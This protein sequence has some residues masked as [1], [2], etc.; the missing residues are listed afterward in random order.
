MNTPFTAGRMLGLLLLT[1]SFFAC[2][3]DDE[4]LTIDYREVFEN[5]AEIVHASYEDSYRTVADLKTA[6]DD[7]VANPTAEGLESAKNLWLV[8]RIP[9]GQ[10]E[11]YRFY[12]GPID[13]ENGPEGLINA[14]PIDENFID[15]VDGNATAGLINDPV[16]YPTID[17][18]TLADLNESISETSIYT[19]YHA[20]EFL[21]WG[22]DLSADGPGERPYTDYV[23]DGTGTADHQARR[24]EYLQVV[25]DLLLDHLAE[26]RDEWA[27]R[28]EY[29]TAFLATD[30]AVALGRIFTSLGELSKGELAG[31]RM[32][33]AVDSKD[34][35]NEHSCFSDNTDTDIRM[36]LEGI[37]NVYYG[38]YTRTGPAADVIQGESL[39]QKAA[40]VDA[41][42]ADAVDAAFQAAETAVE[43]IPRPFDQA[44]LNNETLILNAVEALRELSDRLTDMGFAMGA[45]F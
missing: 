21:L 39:A 43:A 26:V 29:R 9:Y 40:L 28:A 4:D 23:T 3:K 30:D 32:F 35:E 12:G 19:G 34:Q 41:T 22:Q 2:Q 20:I 42:K 11:A 25:T 15:Y 14:W 7:F 6:I 38:I 37:E 24:A 45:E 27:D 13:D 17:K 44:I 18:A 31:E 10:T 8:A 33:V 1:V 36:N 16:N 5:Y